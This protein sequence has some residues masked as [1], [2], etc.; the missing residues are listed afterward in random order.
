M[1]TFA[2][3][4]SILSQSKK[5]KL[6]EEQ[7]RRGA[8]RIVAP[9]SCGEP[10]R[11]I[12]TFSKR[13]TPLGKSTWRGLQGWTYLTLDFPVGI[14]AMGLRCLTSSPQVVSEHI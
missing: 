8:Q 12:F 9:G 10:A 3:S 5:A 14:R 4:T 6:F 11:E 1:P 13:P 2:D 7:A